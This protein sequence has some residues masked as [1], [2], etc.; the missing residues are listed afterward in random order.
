MDTYHTLP[1][2][3]ADDT[4]FFAKRPLTMVPPLSPRPSPVL[5]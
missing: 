4:R 1:V 3:I 5:R 2:L